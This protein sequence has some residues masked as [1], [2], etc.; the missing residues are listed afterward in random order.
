MPN[1]DRPEPDN[2]L[3]QAIRAIQSSDRKRGRA[4]LAGVLSADPQEAQAWLWLAACFDEPDKKRYCLEQAQALRPDD[5][6]IRQALER[7]PAASGS[8]P[9]SPDEALNHEHEPAQPAGE[10]ETSGAASAAPPP[11]TPANKPAQKKKKTP[12][13]PQLK[14]QANSKKGIG[15]L[16]GLLLTLLG[17]LAFASIALL[18]FVLLQS[19]LLALPAANPPPPPGSPPAE[20]PVYQLPPTWTLTPGAAALPSSTR[21]LQATGAAPP[22]VTLPPSITPFT[23]AFDQW[24]IVIG[25][26][27]EA[28]QIEVFRFGLGDRERMII[29]GMH[30]AA[31]GNSAALADQLIAH[32]QAN[33]RLVPEGIT[34]Y[35]LRGLNPDGAALGAAAAGCFNAHGVDLNRN[36]PLNWQTEW[37]GQDCLSTD[38]A[39]AGSTP[40]SEPETQAAAKFISARKIETLINYRSGGAGAYPAGNGGDR[41]SIALAQAID[42][43]SNFHY[44]PRTE[45]CQ[46]TGALVDWALSRG[47]LAAIDLAPSGARDLDF[48]TNLT[49]LNLLL[50]WD[51]V[52]A[53]PLPATPT[54]VPTVT[55]TITATETVP[56]T[57]TISATKTIPSTETPT[58]SATQ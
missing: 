11:E 58:S 50:A 43:I 47:A 17:L 3:E 25:Q 22:S 27:V 41:R 34:L 15:L 48:E 5:P 13:K 6:H 49:I 1:D 56:P 36:F 40:L 52:N 45:D 55:G 54:P 51:P 57:E 28:R 30:G 8:T 26:S 4:L 31:D 10:S 14:L 42:A 18:L 21:A 7:L 16:G 53:T 33:P 24:R 19:N 35:I 2:Q 37:E 39:S 32:L 12:P 9:V 46:S 23:P 20:L 44:P 38:P 29:A